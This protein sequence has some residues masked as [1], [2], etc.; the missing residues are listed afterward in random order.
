MAENL[1]LNDGTVLDNSSAILSSDLFLYMNGYGMK[2]VFDLLIEPEKAKK[3]VY[4]R[5]D[6]SIVSYLKYKKLISVRD[7]GD[8]LITAVL[9]REVNE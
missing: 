4:T 7:E 8:D 5:N 3:I 1:K 6:G 9:R 2:E